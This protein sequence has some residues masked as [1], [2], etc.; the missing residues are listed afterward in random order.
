MLIQGVAS[1]RLASAIRSGSCA[2][3][4]GLGL[5]LASAGIAPTAVPTALAAPACAVA[6]TGEAAACA[7]AA[8]GEAAATAVAA[9][10]DA[11]ACTVAAAPT[12]CVAT[13]WAVGCDGAV[14]AA[15]QAVIAS[16]AGTATTVEINRW[17]LLWLISGPET[18]RTES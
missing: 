16:N 9:A 14:G 4:L 11:P 2:A 18:L 3:G 13:A 7:V 6:A 12:A 8:A 15:P 1:A 17:V 10:G 5:G